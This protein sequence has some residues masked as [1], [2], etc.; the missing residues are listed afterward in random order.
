M[1]G[2][3]FG[4]TTDVHVIKYNVIVMLNKYLVFEKLI[5]TSINT[6]Y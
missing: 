4:H 6:V 1:S 2:C 3:L 5:F